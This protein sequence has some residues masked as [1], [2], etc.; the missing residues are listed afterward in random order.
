MRKDAPH[1]EPTVEDDAFFALHYR[2]AFFYACETRMYD[3]SGEP[4]VGKWYQQAACIVNWEC[5]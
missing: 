4:E 3:G 5:V 1:N 2:S